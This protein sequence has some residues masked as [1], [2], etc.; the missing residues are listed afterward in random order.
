MSKRN[1]EAPKRMN[2]TAQTEAK[3]SSP[4]ENKHWIENDETARQRIEQARSLKE[5]AQKG[6]LRFEVY[7]TPGLAEWILDMVE[8]GDFIDPSEAVFV[9]M[10][11]AQ[12]IEPHDDLKEEILRRRLQKGLDSIEQGRT[13]S[14]DEVWEHINKIRE[15]KA[16]PAVWK[17]IEQPPPE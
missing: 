2:E 10:E 14:A 1:L 6:G 17:K 15:E 7:L 12:E 9:F 13:Y 11:Q 5:I 4:C 3:N 8:H 16:E